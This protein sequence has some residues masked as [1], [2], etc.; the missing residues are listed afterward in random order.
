MV[1]VVAVDKGTKDHQTKGH[2]MVE[3]EVVMGQ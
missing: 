3:V 2:T 1:V